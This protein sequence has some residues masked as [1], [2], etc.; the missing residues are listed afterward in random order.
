LEIVVVGV[1]KP[2]AEDR[3]GTTERLALERPSLDLDAF[4]HAYAAAAAVAADLTEEIPVGSAIP[5]VE[6]DFPPP[7]CKP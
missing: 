4:L 3:T 6:E 1:V 7:M 5:V 2:S